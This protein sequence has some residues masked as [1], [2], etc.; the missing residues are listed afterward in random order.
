MPKLTGTNVRFFLSK[1]KGRTDVG[2]FARIEKDGK[3]Y[4]FYPGEN[5][6]VKA[7]NVARGRAKS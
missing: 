4:T 2:I 7:W 5:I 1:R 6:P 3:I